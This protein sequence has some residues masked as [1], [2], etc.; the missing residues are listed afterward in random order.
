MTVSNSCCWKV[1]SEILPG[2]CARG[3]CRRPNGSSHRPEAVSLRENDM[4]YGLS[5]MLVVEISKVQV[6]EVFRQLVPLVEMKYSSGSGFQAQR[7]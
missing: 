4:F 5:L 7:V 3:K 6:L 2:T 1:K